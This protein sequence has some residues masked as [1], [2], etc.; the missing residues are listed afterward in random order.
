MHPGTDFTFFFS[1]QLAWERWRKDA[2]DALD[3]LE[4]VRAP[5][6]S[7]ANNNIP[8]PISFSMGVLVYNLFRDI[9][10]T[11][12]AGFYGVSTKVRGHGAA[13]AWPYAQDRSEQTP[14]CLDPAVLRVRTVPGRHS[15]RPAESEQKRLR[16]GPLGVVNCRLSSW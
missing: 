8:L 3:S 7:K 16:V 2:D 10:W 4:S 1:L 15:R 12:A 9:V 14:P 5:N 6:T 11:A 13:G